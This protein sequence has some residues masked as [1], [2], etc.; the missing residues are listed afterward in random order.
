MKTIKSLKKLFVNQM[1]NEKNSI[2]LTEQ[3]AER[4]TQ[5]TMLFMGRESQPDFYSSIW[6]VGCDNADWTGF[7]SDMGDFIP[8]D[9]C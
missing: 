8:V 5:S 7:Q 1:L 2:L 3:Q 4:F 9:W 6:F